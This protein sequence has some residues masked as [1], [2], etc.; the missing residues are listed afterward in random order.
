MPHTSACVIPRC[1]RTSS[2]SLSN[3]RCATSA[4]C[5][6]ISAS[7]CASAATLEYRSYS[8][9]MNFSPAFTPSSTSRPAQP[10]APASRSVSTA[11]A[12]S[13]FLAT[14]VASE[15]VA[16]L[17]DSSRLV[18]AVLATERACASAWSMSSSTPSS[19]FTT[20]SRRVI[21]P[22]TCSYCFCATSCLDAATASASFAFFS[23]SSDER[24]GSRTAFHASGL[25]SSCSWSRVR[26]STSITWSASALASSYTCFARA[27]VLAAPLARDSA[28]VA[29]TFAS[30]HG[31]ASSRTRS[32]IFSL[33][34]SG[35]RASIQR[36]KW[37]S[38]CSM[39]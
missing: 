9:S 16:N 39:R 23:A 3:R 37:D 27:S 19:R 6:R 7:V 34:S 26:F 20:S 11:C 10:V 4:A 17:D 8:S 30:W 28:V 38:S 33:S 1:S 35:V 29:V 36:S 18:L 21:R 2:R 22:L 5:A 13:C 15:S 12:N 25:S 32:S 14:A 24:T 31:P